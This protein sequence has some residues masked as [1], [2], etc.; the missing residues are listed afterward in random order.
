MTRAEV[1]ERLTADYLCNVCRRTPR[2]D[3]ALWCAARHVAPDII[4]PLD[5]DSY[6]DATA[7]NEETN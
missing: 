6:D 3:H 1:I 5:G 7:A 2:Y 4:K